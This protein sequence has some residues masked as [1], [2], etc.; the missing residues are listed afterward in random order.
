[1]KI[2]KHQKNLNGLI[3]NIRSVF[4]QT[5]LDC[6]D[7][8]EGGLT[9]QEMSFA[10]ENQHI[11]ALKLIRERTGM[12]IMEAKKCVEKWQRENGVDPYGGQH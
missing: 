12:G 11:P 10:R 9:A 5:L 8:S 7:T 6:L 4:A 2:V 1:M 3:K